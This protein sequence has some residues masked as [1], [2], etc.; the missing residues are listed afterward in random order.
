MR[1]FLWSRSRSDFTADGRHVIAGGC[2]QGLCLYRRNE[3]QG[4]TPHGSGCRTRGISLC[5]RGRT[6]FRCPV[7]Q[8]G[9]HAAAGIGSGLGSGVPPEGGGMDAPKFGPQASHGRRTEDY[10]RQRQGKMPWTSGGSYREPLRKNR[11]GHL[12][13]EPI[14]DEIP[15][16]DVQSCKRFRVLSL[17][18]EV[19]LVTQCAPAPNPA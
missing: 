8:S 15:H 13:R 6:A 17:S 7:P 1:N 2:G 10:L 11:K 4:F 9:Q 5:V 19:H 18:H 16:D 12:A 14:V 3:R